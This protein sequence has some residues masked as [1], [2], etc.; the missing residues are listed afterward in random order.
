[1]HGRLS[2]LIV[3]M[4]GSKSQN[5][6]STMVEFTRRK[7]FVVLTSEQKISNVESMAKK[8]DFFISIRKYLNSSNHA[9][10]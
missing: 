8:S 7:V 5:N 6:N 2:K 10:L 9:S 4:K 3:L 1:M